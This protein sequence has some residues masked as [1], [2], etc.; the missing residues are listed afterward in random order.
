MSKNLRRLTTAAILT[1]VIVVMAFTPLGYLKAGPVE[2]TFLTIPVVIGAILLGPAYGAWL[3]VVFGA[4]SFA[5]CVLGSS[6]FGAALLSIHPVGTFLCT[7]LPR[8]MVGL[9]PAWLFR[10]LYRGNQLGRALV[11]TSLAGVL[12]NTVL[13]IGMVVAIFRN[14]YFGGSP[15]W[16]IFL[17]F[18]TLNVAIE[19]VVSCV[20]AAGLSRVL[21]KIIS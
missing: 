13:F 11:L 3:G 7:M 8:I 16:T 1:A 4:S 14:T 9:V 5:T 21:A 17:S 2:I 12:T 20:A 6:V 19:I 15:F 18:F 10:L